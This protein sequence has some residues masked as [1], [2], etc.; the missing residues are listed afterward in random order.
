LDTSFNQIRQYAEKNPAVMIRL[1]DAFITISS[2]AENRNQRDHI[3]KHANMVMNAAEHSFIET[4]D[5]DTIRSKYIT[6]K[7]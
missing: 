3:L 7:L 4:Q 6:L 5:L 2:F 1:M